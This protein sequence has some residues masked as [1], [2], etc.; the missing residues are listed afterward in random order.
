MLK[1]VPLVLLGG[2]VITH[3]PKSSE[4]ELIK[5]KLN[6]ISVYQEELKVAVDNQDEEAQYFFMQEILKIELKAYH[7]IDVSENPKIRLIK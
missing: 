7:N 1:F 6:W 4:T 3:N 5:S 2:C